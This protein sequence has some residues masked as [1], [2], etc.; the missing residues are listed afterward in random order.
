MALVTCAVSAWAF[1]VPSHTQDEITLLL[2]ADLVSRGWVPN[3]DFFTPYGPGTFWPL[4]GVFALTGGPSVM[5]GRFVGLLYHV[6]LAT[7][8]WALLRREGAAAGL[9]AGI[10]TGL[11]AVGLLLTPYGWLLAL[12]L[13]IWSTVA[14]NSGRFFLA[15][16]AAALAGSVRPEFVV[17]SFAVAT[18]GVRSR[19]GLLRYGAGALLAGVPL[20][21]HL[22]L[23]GDDLARNV[24]LERMMTDTGQPLPPTS[25]ALSLTLLLVLLTMA[26]MTYR[27]IRLRCRARTTTLL[28]CWLVLPQLLQR[29][30]MEHALF[31]LVLV[32]PLCLGEVVQLLNSRST[33]RPLPLIATRTATALAVAIVAIAGA[34]VAAKVPRPAEARV[35]DRVLFA[36]SPTEAAI[37]EQVAVELDRRLDSGGTIFVGLTDMSYAGINA[38]FIYYLLPQHVPDEVYFLDLAP[39]VSEQPGS[40]LLRDVSTA[41]I[42]VLSSFSRQQ[43]EALFPLLERGSDR[44][45]RYVRDHFCP[46]QV[47]GAF[48]IRERCR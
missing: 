32:G 18:V 12:A 21:V 16:T 2:H 5:G 8:V 14:C 31:V 25:A 6:F 33:W 44:V 26:F 45:N 46:A 13:T 29:A 7:S 15:G 20:L 24:V 47:I 1:W 28:L 39:G 23:A 19:D 4:A 41:E 22:W 35:G 9:A 48:E 27:A 30:D 42:V 17:L 38:A 11:I 34:F 10:L 40:R 37:Q 43:G 3:R 36:R